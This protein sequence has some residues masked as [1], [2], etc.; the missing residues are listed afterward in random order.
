ML[1]LRF[2]SRLALAALLSTA[3][4]FSTSSAE[5]RLG[6][7]VV[8]TSQSVHLRLDAD[9]VG[10]RGSVQFELQVR[11]PTQTIQLH[12]ESMTFTSAALTQKGREIPV[13]S[14]Q[15]EHGL[16]TLTLAKPVSVGPA[17]LEI[18]FNQEFNTQAVSL[19]RVEVGGKGYAFAQF[20]PDDAREA[21]P[22]WDEPIFKIP[23]RI[24]LEVPE[25]HR[26]VSNSPVASDA[27]K[28]GWRTVVF[29]K[30]PPTSTY[31]LT[32]ATGPFEFTPIPGLSA[33]GRIVTVEGQSALAGPAATMAAPLLAGC[34]KYFGRPYPYEKLDLIAVPEYWAGAMENPGAITY[35]DNI[36]LIDPKAASPAQK[37]NLA[38][39]HAHEFAHMWFGDL[40]TMVWWDDLWLNES[41]ADW[42]GD[43]ITDQV[44]PE[45]QLRLAELQNVQ[46]IM[47]QDALLSTAAI[48]R[49]VESAETALDD[50]QIAYNKGKAVL[51]M[52]ESWIGP[53]TF[54]KGVNA[55]L[56]AHEWR[57]AVS[58]DLWR[59][60]GQASGQDVASALEGFIAQPGLPLVKVEPLDGGE[61][62][63]SQQRFAGHGITAPPLTWKIPVGI[64]YW[65]GAKVRTTRVLLGENSMTVKLEGSAPSTW[66]MPNSGAI[67][68]YRWSVPHE[69]LLEVAKQSSSVL[70]PDERIA[71]LG[72]LG[73]L[74]DAGQ[75]SGDHYLRLL[76]EFANDPE[77]QVVS[78]LIA[79]LGKVRGAFVPDAQLETFAPYVRRVLGPAAQRFGLEPKPGESEAIGIVRPLL[80]TWLGYYGRDQ[81]TLRAAERLAKA[82]LADPSSVEPG[83]AGAAL[84]LSAIRGDRALF[85]EYRRRFEASK[86]PAE[87]LRYLLALGKFDDPALERQALTYALEGP[88]RA[89]EVFQIVTSVS[90]KSERSQ[91]L[92]FAFQ[93]ENFDR[94]K[95]KLPPAYWP[96]LVNAAGGCS[97]ERL[98]LG[99]TFY[100]APEHK[101]E[102]TQRQYDQ[103]RD[104]VQS[105]AS[106]RE[107]EGA[108]VTAYLG[109]LVGA[110]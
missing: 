88:V 73:A 59:A 65:D 8:P 76:A 68:Y 28:D 42:M 7:D 95:G 23:F 53:E 85:D 101:V 33:P 43:K 36:L 15:G 12:A 86:V 50:V 97:L 96:F 1:P 99:R 105:C 82:Y 45:F 52:F 63:L 3:V 19:Y 46:N 6:Q 77:P 4:P 94:V 17:K 104:A 106:L 54:R 78:S 83:V 58:A 10:Y 47:E 35:R 70:D 30:T 75:V 34:E 103:L 41:F 37:R 48:Q 51:S 27:V 64:K 49:P 91:N 62:R 21:F 92:A 66:V 39:I 87:R 61:V 80:M 11:K 25:R 2:T 20:E 16:L 74:L 40:V 79:G 24:T 93:R 26:A 89:Q 67:G 38:R 60:L 100:L 110:R 13:D 72:N 69:M 108:K 14:K 29:K 5:V 57:N 9:E 107:R 81:S 109:S 55:Y 84:Q 98:E 18:A 102:G 32:V 90:A 56:K 71:L 44:Y 31:L 22:C